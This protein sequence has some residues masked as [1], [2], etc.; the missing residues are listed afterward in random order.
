MVIRNLHVGG[1]A[2]RPAKA[3]TPLLIHADAVPA[4]EVPFEGLEPVARRHSQVFESCRRV[5][6]DE[7]AVHDI[8]KVLRQPAGYVA[9]EKLLGFGVGETLNHPGLITQDVNSVK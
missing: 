9:P 7:F 4:L 8:L 2:F 6:H 5:D 1:A 3:D